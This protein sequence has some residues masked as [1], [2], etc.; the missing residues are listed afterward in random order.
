AREA[1]GLAPGGW[2]VIG[3]ARV[4]AAVEARARPARSAADTGV[5]IGV[6]ACRVVPVPGTPAG[7]RRPYARPV[8][9]AGRPGGPGKVARVLAN[10]RFAPPAKIAAALQHLV[11]SSKGDV[12]ALVLPMGAGRV[13]ATDAAGGRSYLAEVVHFK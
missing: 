1:C 2:L 8:L 12:Q 11:P 10:R 7:R 9:L 6:R 5:E 3:L 13:V 4:L